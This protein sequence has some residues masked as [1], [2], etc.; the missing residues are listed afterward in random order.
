MYTIQ[1]SKIQENDTQQTSKYTLLLSTAVKVILLSAILLSVI[2]LSVI[3]LSVILLSVILQECHG[4][5]LQLPLLPLAPSE[6]KKLK[7]FRS[8]QI[9]EKLSSN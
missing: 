4:A 1:Q 7:L 5:L 3:L 6:K 9:L 2:L 8:L